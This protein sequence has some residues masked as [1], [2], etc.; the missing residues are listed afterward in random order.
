MQNSKY[1]YS[2]DSRFSPQS[3]VLSPQSKTVLF[4]LVVLL[5]ACRK[6]EA[7]KPAAALPPRPTPV[8]APRFEEKADAMGIH[9]IHVN[10]ARGDKW[11]PET[12][13]GG[14]AVLDYDGDGKPDLLFVSSAWWPGDPRAQDQSL[15]PETSRER[16]TRSAASARTWVRRGLERRGKD[17]GLPMPRLPLRP[18]R[19]S[20]PWPRDPSASAGRNPRIDPS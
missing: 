11:M 3:Q 14:V 12:M 18:D 19:R 4:A 10:G 1:E 20:P 17:L 6:Q 8:P 13:G 7:V 15:S 16:S 5:F 9:F 2:G